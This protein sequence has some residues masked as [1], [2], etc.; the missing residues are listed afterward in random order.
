MDRTV[1]IPEDVYEQLEW[2]A[3]SRHLGS[4]ERLLRE[5]AEQEQAERKLRRAAAVSRID[6]L[7]EQIATEL[8]HLPNVDEMIREARER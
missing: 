2:A 4:V 6:K 1:T 7:R 3:R 8:T 5:V